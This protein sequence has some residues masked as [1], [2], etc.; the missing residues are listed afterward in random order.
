MSE[1]A[2]LKEHE[3]ESGEDYYSIQ[4]M[5]TDRNR[6]RHQRLNKHMLLV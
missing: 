3:D 1:C 4:L 2:S 5:F 6:G